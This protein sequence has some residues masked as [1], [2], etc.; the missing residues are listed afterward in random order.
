MG[1]SNYRRRLMLAIAN[2]IKS[3]FGKGMWLDNVIWSDNDGWN[4]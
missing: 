4:E 1:V 2:L 3:C